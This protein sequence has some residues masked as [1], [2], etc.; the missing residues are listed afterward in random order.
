MNILTKL[1]EVRK[2]WTMRMDADDSEENQNKDKGG[3]KYSAFSTRLPY[4]LCKDVGID[5]EGMTP[6]EAWDAYY[7]KTGESHD[8]VASAKMGK[9]APKTKKLE[10]M[11]ES[12]LIA[13]SDRAWTEYKKIDQEMMDKYDIDVLDAS[14]KKRYGEL[15]DVPH[16]EEIEKL[17]ER[18]DEFAKA[19]HD[20]DYAST[21]FHDPK[22]TTEL[23]QM[24]VD[25]DKAKADD[26]W[27]YSR[28]G[29]T[30]AKAKEYRAKLTEAKKR[31]AE[32]FV[33]DGCKLEPI[34]D[35]DDE[36]LEKEFKKLREMDRAVM[37]LDDLD[38]EDKAV[39]VLD[40]RRD[41]IIN[42]FKDKIR[43]DMGLS[44]AD[45]STMS[46]SALKKE[47]KGIKTSL[48]KA[49]T[50]SD[51]G[52]AMSKA[53]S[54][55]EEE[56]RDRQDAIK[57]ELNKRGET[58]Y[59][60]KWDKPIESKE[61]ELNYK[62][63]VISEY[64][65]L[66]DAPKVAQGIKTLDG[67]NKCATEYMENR[68]YDDK[69]DWQGENKNT[70]WGLDTEGLVNLQS[71]MQ[72][73]FDNA[74][75]CLNINSANIDDVLTG[76]L[77][78]QFETGTTDGSDDL[79]ARRDLSHNIFGTPTG[80]KK[81]D[82]EKYGYLA[83]KD[84]FDNTLGDGGPWY[85]EKGDGDRCTI[86]FKKDNVKDRTTYTLDDSLMG[87]TDY[88]HRSYAAGI[89]DTT[90][91]IEGASYNP[92][93]AVRIANGEVQSLKDLYHNPYDYCEAQYHGGVL[94]KDIEQIRFKNYLD[95]KN[96][97]DSWDDN[98]IK[99]IKEN[100]IKVRSYNKKLKRWE[101]YDIDDLLN[102]PKF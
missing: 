51:Y 17:L 8:A 1:E 19:R 52:S 57:E 22:P 5:T 76:H 72:K 67:W 21:H 74:D 29:G 83:D 97:L 86:V 25:I 73:M 95:M 38:K 43:Q 61:V 63:P 16:H 47:L 42:K 12:E 89:V 27:A 18:A 23:D 92:A 46:E 102:A 13:E 58:N 3:K 77:K 84:D 54:T 98:A 85:G 7:Q 87:C 45:P 60:K 40:S 44:D 4:G 100:G 35:L 59:Q 41:A 9:E 2:R 48:E 10:D 80:T 68:A 78:N 55:M 79:S 53:A 32:K 65:G 11:S 20:A 49:Y 33:E 15:K 34:D 36:A 62:K 26:A 94:A 99:A 28:W 50:E 70:L 30:D 96:A 82:R 81:E 14:L 24:L 88:G 64:A 39:S 37:T 93:Y 56:T 6:R 66:V 69:G 71:N 90:C 31:W 75:F 101:D 91:S